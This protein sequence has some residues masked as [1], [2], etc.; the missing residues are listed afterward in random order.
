MEVI[1]ERKTNWLRYYFNNFYI[2]FVIVDLYQ[3]KK[4]MKIVDI[5][6]E[7]I[8]CLK[9]GQNV[10]DRWN[11]IIANVLSFPLYSGDYEPLVTNGS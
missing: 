8:L 11:T 5:S 1:K 9:I 3:E 2:Y 6:K 10:E 4:R 7:E